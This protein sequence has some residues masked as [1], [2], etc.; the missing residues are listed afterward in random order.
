MKLSIHSVWIMSQITIRQSVRDKTVFL[1]SF[2]FLILV[3]VSAYL[4]WSATN[5]VN[6]I[7]LKTAV[8]LAANGLPVPSNPVLESSPLV[9]L[10]NM[11]TYV[12][13]IGALAAIVLG[14]QMVAGDRKAGV[15]PLIGSRPIQT[16][17]FALAKIVAVS[18]VL[19]AVL[20]IASLIN[21]L[22]F[23]LLPAFH[24]S[25][26]E[27]QHLIAFYLASGLYM[28]FFGLLGMLFSALAKNESIA[29]LV[30]VTL[31]LT[32]T[33]I[34]PQLTSSINPMAS[35]NP[36]SATAAAPTSA[37]FHYSTLILHPIS[38]VEVY[39]TVSAQL[40]GF[41]PSTSSTH[42]LLEG[43][44]QLGG[45]VLLLMGASIWSITRMDMSKGDY[46]E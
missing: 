40:L 34:F 29:L 35:L 21:T 32:L 7:Y 43:F 25:A 8:F 33:F 27:W 15:L 24:L 23:L 22:T 3:L 30:P 20:L 28:L 2:L 36:L 37:F 14:Y 6:A 26:I 38:M 45:G 1:L 10:R 44:L 11:N 46:S 19:G 9:L 42:S 31:W 17:Q 12:S 18:F 13:L 41:Q 39:R 16:G 4:G 5:T